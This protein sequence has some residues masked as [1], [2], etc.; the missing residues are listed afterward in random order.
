MKTFT[1]KN[2]IFSEAIK[3]MRDGQITLEAGRYYLTGTSPPYWGEAPTPGVKIY[4]SDDLL[5]WKYEKLLIDRNDLDE[6][7]WY[8]DYFWA[9]EI[10]VKADKYYLTFN[11]RN[12]QYDP[13]GSQHNCGLAV[14]DEILGPYTVLTH[15]A[16]LGKEFKNDISLFTD[17]DGH[18]YAYCSGRGVWQSRIDLENGR[19]IGDFEKIIDKTDDGDWQLGGVEGPCV[20][21]RQGVYYLFYSAWTRGYEIGYATAEHPLGPWR[22]YEGNPIFGTRC[23]EFR[24]EQMQFEGTSHLQF[25]DTPDPYVEVGHNS[26]FPGPDGRDWI[27]C[28]YWLKGK[29]PIKNPPLPMQYEDTSPQ[30]GFD[31][32]DIVDGKVIAHGP[33][34]TEQTVNIL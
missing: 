3:S 16:P 20:I 26:I 32:I 33:T 1:Y 30:L 23:R 15:D 9:P 17:D 34:F 21:K 28:H 18:S 8:R 13:Q 31:P 2:P 10:H 22:L 27:V 11:C 19:L 12:S 29:K 5:K 25:E 7:V 14:A 4:S 24:E 6:N